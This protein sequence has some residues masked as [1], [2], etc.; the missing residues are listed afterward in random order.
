MAAL[1]SAPAQVAAAAEPPV[2]SAPGSFNDELGCGSDWDVGCE[3]VK[4]TLDEA[5]G[6]YTGHFALPEGD[7]EFKIAQD[8]SWDVNWGVDGVPGGDNIAFTVAGGAQTVFVF[9]PV[10]KLAVAATEDQLLTAPGSYQSYAGCSGTWDPACLA[11][12]L[13]PTSSGVYTTST[14]KIPEGSWEFKVAQGLSWD[15]NWGDGGAPGG[16]NVEFATSAGENVTFTFDPATHVPSAVAENPP[17]PGLGRSYALWIDRNTIAWPPT[18]AGDPAAMA[19]ELDGHPEIVLAAAG[20]VTADQAAE[21]AL[22]AGYTALRLS[23]PGGGEVAQSVLEEALKGR[24]QVVAT[25]DAAVA[26]Q[27]GV[28]IAGV[29]DDLYAGAADEQLGVIWANGQPT[30]KLWAPTAAKVELLVYLDGAEAAPAAITAT[31]DANG[32]W[33]AVGQASWKNAQYL[34]AVDVYVPSAGEV[35]TNTVTDP[36]SIALTVNSTRSVLID[37]EDPAWAPQLWAD[38]PIP[39]A[40]RTQAAQTIYELQIR[41][42]SIADTTVPE[43]WRGTYKAFTVEDSDGM[44]HLRELADAGMTTVHLLPSFDIASIPELRDDQAVPDIPADAA[45][46]SAAQQAAVAATADSDGFNWGYDPWHWTTPEGSYAT[47]GNQDGGAR[48]AEF[49]EMV[50]GLHDA[51]L[52]VVLDEVFNHTSDAG[53]SEKSV[54]DKI[55]P[56]YY[57]RL[58]ATGQIET[59][60]C[61]QNVATENLMAGKMMVDSV[62]TWVKAYHVDGFR[63]DI[64]GHHSL[65]NMKD[66]RAALDELTVAKDGVD[67]KAVYLYGEAWNFGEVQDDALFVQARQANI[68]GTGIGTFNDRLRD[69]VRGGGPFD[70]DQR[71]MQGFGTG[72]YTDANETTDQTADQQLSDLYYRTNMVRLGLIGNLKAYPMPDNEGKG[73]I[74]LGDELLYAGNQIAGY[75]DDPTEVINYVDA[76]DNETLYDNGIWKLPVDSTM[77]TRIRM[78]TLSLAT[79]TLGQAPAFWHAGADI[80]RS[81]SLDRN[82]YN[83]GDHFNAIDWSLETNVFGTG[84]PMAGDNSSKWADMA[85]LLANPD[86]KPDQA[87]MEQAYEGALDLLRLRSSTPLFTLGTGDLVV[88]RVK[89]LAAGPDPTPGLLVMSVEDPADGSS[90]IDPAIDE[91]LIVFNASPDPITETL[92]GKAGLDF[93]LHQVQQDGSDPVVRQTVWDAA[94]GSVTIPGRTVAV[95]V[96]APAAEPVEPTEPATPTPEPTTPTAEPTTPTPE[97]ATPTPEP[98]ATVASPTQPAADTGSLADTGSAAGLGILAASGLTL[99]LTGAVAIACSR[100][101]RRRAAA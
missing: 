50:G 51:G 37:L 11:S 62:V 55:V 43:A 95:L 68:A 45:P 22:A 52:R 56:G 64:M 7:Y 97:P 98:S 39:A 93:S 49:R 83:S 84:L 9:D 66:V 85:P 71:T 1:V 76:H 65:Q 87:D 26:A 99:L 72:L 82:S 58:S 42:F 100:A 30:L 35:V 86:L 15:K 78:N 3:A 33:A 40:L 46:D 14:S 21:H 63:F 101:D 18:L 8:Q 29:L 10:S 32:V 81:K 75:A 89:F 70:A 6:H 61:C 19:Y 90:D 59:T 5:S 69:G 41:D 28:Q 20:E 2:I 57:Q 48:T 13:F 91:L 96:R 47:D 88:D 79:V 67:G 27:T 34:W 44:T 80:L 16:G 54:L 73:E 77:D 36:Y 92:D 94:A 4:L 24:L 74:V 25:K 23:A 60:T 17:L 31:R 53:Q 12:V 38:T